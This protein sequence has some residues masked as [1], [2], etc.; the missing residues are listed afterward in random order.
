MLFVYSTNRGAAKALCE[1]G[2]KVTLLDVLQDPT[3]STPYLTPT[4]GLHV[5]TGYLEQKLLNLFLQKY[6]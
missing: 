6:N 5:F 3:G 1:N 2:C 4:G